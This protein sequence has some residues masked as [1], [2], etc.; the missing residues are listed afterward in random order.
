MQLIPSGGSLG[1][2]VEGVDLARL[3]QSEFDAAYAALARHGVL[4]FPRQT[5]SSRELRE[6]AA[7]WGEL[8]VNVAN[9][10]QEPGLP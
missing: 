3:S 6:F 10:F 7:R 8:E 1:A 5:L 4:R 2:T 9:M